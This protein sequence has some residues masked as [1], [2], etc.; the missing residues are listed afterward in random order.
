MTI[1]THFQTEPKHLWEN[2]YNITQCPRPSKKEKK[3][4]DYVIGL[5]NKTNHKFIQDEIGNIIVY[6]PGT[7]GKEKNETVII[8]NHLDMVTDS[9]PDRKINFENDP[10]TTYEEN[11]WL[12]A[13]GTTLGSDNGIGCAAALAL[14]TDKSVAHPPL[15]LLFTIDE[16]SGMSG[17]KAVSKKHFSGKK[18]INLDTEEWGKFYIGCAGGM[19]YEFKKRVKI[20]KPDSKN[21]FYKVTLG[22]IRGGHSG[23]DIHMQQGN[24]IKLLTEVLQS[25]TSLN[26]E[27]SE[28]RSGRAHNIIP[29]DAFVI[30]GFS[31]E[32]LNSFKS[33]CDNAISY[34][35][36][37]LPKEDHQLTILI[38][39][40]ATPNFVMETIEQKSFLN[41]LTIFPHGAHGYVLDSNKELVNT[42][43]NLAMVFLVG[44]EFYLLTSGRFFDRNEAIKVE[45]SFVSF[46]EIFNFDTS[47]LGEYPSWKP[48]FHNKLLDLLK[49]EYKILYKKEATVT[50][51]HA[52]LECGILKKTL[53]EMDIV[54]FG[55]TIMGAHS[56]TERCDMGTVK[57]FWKLFVAVLNKL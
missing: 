49:D 4:C 41:A 15:E 2:F 18:M 38:E 33:I 48:I 6:V 46:G 7:S 14:L 40:I 52:G 51:I 57:E 45:Q 23:V 11:G 44:E 10:I 37:Y 16:E 12:K 5:A 3:V 35:K 36:G 32:K 54:S 56:P 28:F 53:G 19:E 55:P 50:A 21:T 9:T 17:A 42:S 30:I 31:E 43:N 1:P 26:Y 13:H 24:A 27:L 25:S 34:L 8:Q 47:K 22:N 29:R 39:K 20:K